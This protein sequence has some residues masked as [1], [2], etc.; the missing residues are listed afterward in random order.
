MDHRHAGGDDVNIA[1]I[2]PSTGVQPG[3]EDRVD[4]QRRR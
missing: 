1:L 3:A 2:R 4:D